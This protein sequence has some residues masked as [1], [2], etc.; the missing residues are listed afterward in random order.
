VTNQF[1]LRAINNG[2]FSGQCTQLCGLY[3]SLMYF[4]VKVVSPADY[5]NW[6]NSFNNKADE[7]KAQAA[8]TSLQQELST[9][10]AAKPAYTK[11][12]R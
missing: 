9:G 6:L 12:G 8:A 7:I 10:V 4:R 11:F 2:T 3:H 1:T 5:Q